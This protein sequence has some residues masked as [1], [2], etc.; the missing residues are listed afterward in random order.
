M[1]HALDVQSLRKK[2]PALSRQHNGREIIFFDGPGGTQ[3]PQR[4]I[5][6]MSSYLTHSNSNL[7]GAYIT[8]QETVNVLAKAR[9]AAADLFNAQSNEVFFGANMTSLTFSM[10]RAL[11]QTWQRGDEIIITE[12]DHAANTSTWQQAAR[13]AGVKVRVAK[14][15]FPE[16][17][18]DMEYLK[19]LLNEK[20]R[21]VA[22]THA[23]HLAGTLVDV[24]KITTLAH[25][26][27]ALVYVDAVHFAPHCSIDV[28]KIDC[29]FLACSAYKFFGTHV[30]ICYGKHQHLSSLV[31]YKVY[32]AAEVVPAKFETGTQSFEGL[33]GMIAAI[34]YLAGLGTGAS[35]RQCL[36]SGFEALCAYEQ[37]LAEYFLNKLSG[38]SGYRL[39]GLSKLTEVN[40]R[41]PTFSLTFDHI[42]PAVIAE[43]LGQAGICVWH[44]LFYA[45]LLAKATGLDQQGGVLRIGLTHYNNYEE[46]DAF[47]EELAPII[48]A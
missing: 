1:Q 42:K 22:V 25:A 39:Y 34:D 20:T 13:D 36:V 27:G 26:L 30:G 37:Q 14:A 2:F 24:E 16:C 41:T 45:D 21:L 47:F 19:S 40:E 15:I 23:S 32:P 18:L 35:R 9:E 33:V 5:A 28:K 12:L 17:R 11:A 10:S 43:A 7:G 6:A 46:I 29:D 4:V 44:G 3:V 38:F 8:S 48:S 31:P